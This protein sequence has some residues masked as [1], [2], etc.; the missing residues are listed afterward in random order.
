MTDID[1]RLISCGFRP[2]TKRSVPSHAHGTIEWH[3]V[4]AGRCGFDIA[5]RR[6]S[7]ATG[8]LF[9]VEPGSVHGVR[10]RRSEDWLLQYT[11]QAELID[12]ADH[13]LW[14]AWQKTAGTSEVISVGSDRN[15]LFARLTHEMQTRDSWRMLAASHRFTALLCDCI[16]KKAPVEDSHPH[17]QACLRIMHQSLYEL[18]S[19]DALAE[20]VNLNKSYVIR[21]FKQHVGQAPL[22][23]FTDMK[24][25]MAARMLRDENLSVQDV[26]ERIGYAAAAHF[27]RQFKRWSGMSPAH[28]VKAHKDI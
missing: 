17:V 10:M 2:L 14:K 24:M 11:A 16:A 4:I 12:E 28:Y 21:L 15:E 18:L 7:I 27:S 19:V 13:R 20:H 5:K 6:L 9:A 8:D 25:A 1:M 26:S 22:Q 3:Y 23:Y